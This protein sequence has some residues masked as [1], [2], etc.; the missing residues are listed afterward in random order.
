[1]SDLA[2]DHRSAPPEGWHVE[3]WQRHRYDRLYV[4]DADGS[5]VGSFDLTSGEAHAVDPALEDP[6]HRMIDD[7]LLRWPTR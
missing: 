4:R 5:P 6:V 3:R 2:R 1:M 7:W